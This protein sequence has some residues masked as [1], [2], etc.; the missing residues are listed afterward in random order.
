MTKA[1]LRPVWWREWI[2]L[3]HQFKILNAISNAFV[4]EPYFPDLEQGIVRKA[5]SKK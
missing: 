4:L 1:G 5:V 3:T 2:E